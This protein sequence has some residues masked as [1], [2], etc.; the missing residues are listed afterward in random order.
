ML[1]RGMSYLDAVTAEKGRGGGCNSINLEGGDAGIRRVL[2]HHGV[3][4]SA[5]LHTFDVMQARNGSIGE[6]D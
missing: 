1:V 4:L 5:C 6:A 2:D 3:S